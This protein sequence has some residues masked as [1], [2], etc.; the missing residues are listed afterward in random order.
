M[1]R[2]ITQA[3]RDVDRAGFTLVELLTV[4]AIIVL[5]IALLFPGFSSAQDR[6]R[7]VACISNQRNIVAGSL[8]YAA[9][10]EGSVPRDDGPSN[11]WR[12]YMTAQGGTRYVN[13]FPHGMGSVYAKRYVNEAR[14]FYCPSRDRDGSAN[15]YTEYWGRIGAG[16]LEWR[17]GPGN[18][19]RAGY[20]LNFYRISSF[21]YPV[22]GD[23]I[24]DLPHLRGIV[25]PPDRRILTI[26][27]FRNWGA[28]PG[29]NLVYHDN[30]VV[31]SKLDGSAGGYDKTIAQL[32][33]QTDARANTIDGNYPVAD[34][35]VADLLGTA[36]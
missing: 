29:R 1:R 35:I 14:S 17:T 4:I 23:S 27:V 16:P 34:L 11:P 12:T 26:D 13:D 32:R 30:V 28:S 2:G 25:L 19:A 31:L 33:Y 8:L 3:G 15:T 10:H 7:V 22:L 9:D 21:A 6:A 5:L 20:Y 18:R 36:P 24:T